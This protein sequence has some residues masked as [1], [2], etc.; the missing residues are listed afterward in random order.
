VFACVPRS[1][2]L[3][4]V[5]LNGRVALNGSS[6]MS[7]L[8]DGIENEGRSYE[9]EQLVQENKVVFTEVHVVLSF[10]SPYFML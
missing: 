3:Y 9:V 1:G 6:P 7:M 8:L 2:N 4:D 5:T 10:V